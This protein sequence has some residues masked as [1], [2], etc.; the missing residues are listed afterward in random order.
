[1][2]VGDKTE[3]MAIVAVV[4]SVSIGCERDCRW[5]LGASEIDLS[6]SADKNM[7]TEVVDPQWV[8]PKVNVCN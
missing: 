8:P 2:T 5:C 6:E 4:I 3:A 7:F 1:M